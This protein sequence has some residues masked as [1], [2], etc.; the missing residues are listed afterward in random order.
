MVAVRGDLYAVEPNHGEID[1]IDPSTGEIT[2]LVDVS[3]SHGHIVPTAI[4]Y[5]GNF[6]FSQLGEFPVQSGSQSI[7]KVT[8]SG[9]IRSVAT[10][11]TTV[12]GLTFGPDERLY[13]LESMTQDG[14]PFTSAARARVASSG[15]SPPE[16]RP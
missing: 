9:Q 16:R 7:F 11:L 10:G 3:A 5:H 14:F 2:R 15:S 13:A 6:Y 1:R 12:L 4:A 8:P